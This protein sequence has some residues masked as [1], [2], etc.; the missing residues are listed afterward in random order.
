MKRLL[1]ILIICLMLMTACNLHKD[2]AGNTQNSLT[3]NTSISDNLSVLDSKDDL[4]KNDLPMFKVLENNIIMDTDDYEITFEPETLSVSAKTP[5]GTKLTI[6]ESV[7]ES[8]SITINEEN[9]TVDYEDMPFSINYGYGENGFYI[10]FT[11]KEAS[12]IS[13]PQTKYEAE[14]TSLILPMNEGCYVPLNNETWIDYLTNNS[15]DTLS[16]LSMP[17]WGVEDSDYIITYMVDYPFYNTLEFNRDESMVDLS[18]THAFSDTFDTDI[19][20]RYYFNIDKATSPIIPAKHFRKYLESTEQIVTLEDKMNTVDR[21]NSLIGAPH[22]YIWGDGI[23]TEMIDALEKAG[24]DKFVLTTDGWEP[25]ELSPEVATYAED[26]GYLLG[27][28][29]SYHSIHDPK[30]AGTDESWSTAQFGEELYKTGYI[31]GED[32]NP[33]TGFKKF[34]Y[35]L[36]PIAARP[37]VEKRVTDNFSKV[38]YSYYFVDCDAFGEYYNDYT[39]GRM[40]SQRQDVDARLDRLNW[41]SSTFNVPIGS[42]GGNYMFAPAITIAEGIFTSVVGWDDADMLDPKSVYFRGRYWPPEEPEISFKTVPLKDK[43]VCLHYDPRFKLPLYEVVFHDS[44]ISSAH[45]G[46]SSLKFSNVEKM[47]AITEILYQVPSVYHLNL[48]ALEKN[49]VKI[50]TQSELF[51]ETHSYSYKYV[52]QDF[53]YLTEDRSVQMSTFG[54]LVLVANYS[55]DHYTFNGTDI[56]SNSILIINNGKE[57]IYTP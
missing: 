10:S 48:N 45:G 34:G 7:I 2:T 25:L 16:G 54:K 11:P 20:I 29:D 40:A 14:K 28:Y 43:Y 18:F 17:F 41:I 26:H 53:Q 13:W 38:A 51:E 24:L 19:P 30:Y 44:V 47:N 46:S 56:P 52:M 37:Y 21:I 22:A 3:D 50:L 49:K 5:D 57:Q 12:S 4:P 23:S 27:T 33:L 31:T 42:E 35:K 9:N 39:P 32:G 55:A 36:S 15:F 1:P 8:K 6:S